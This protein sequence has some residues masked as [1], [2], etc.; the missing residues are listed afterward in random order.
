MKR[1]SKLFIA[2]PL[3]FGA[4]TLTGCS[5]FDNLANY[6]NEKNESKVYAKGIKL[7]VKNLDGS[8]NNS[9][10]IECV[11]NPTNTTNQN[12]TW[13]SS[14]TGVCTV[15]DGLVNC[16][17]LGEA[18]ITAVSEDGGFTDTCNVT[19]RSKLMTG[20]SLSKKTATLKPGKS[21]T[22]SVVFEPNDCS[23]KAITWTSSNPSI[24]SVDQ[25][26]VITAANDA[27]DGQTATITARAKNFIYSDSCEVTILESAGDLEKTE[28]AWTYKD[29]SK[30]S[31]YNSKFCPTT[32]NVKL[33]V[34]PVWFTDSQLKT[35]LNET[36]RETVREDIRKT[37]FGTQGETGWHS[38]KT[39]YETE[40]TED[41]ENLLTLSGTVSEWF[42]C[43]KD[44]SRFATD[45]AK[46][47]NTDSFAVE[48]TDWYFANHPSDN[49]KNYDSDGDG[50]LDGVMLIY[51]HPDYMTISDHSY[52][53][54]WAYCHW[55]KG[56]PNISSPRPDV[57]FWASYDFMYGSHYKVGNYAGGDNTGAVVD[58]HT[59][60][61][62]MGH[63]FGLED[64]YDYSKQKNPA[65]CFSMQDYNIGGH[66]P[67]SMISLG[68]V[69][70]YIPTDTCEIKLKPFQTNHDVILLTPEM[71]PYGSPFDEY[72]LIEYYTPT[73]LNAL[74][75]SRKYKNSIS[76]PND[77]GIRVWHVDARV[78]GW[79]GPSRDDVLPS[80]LGSNIELS[81]KV[82]QAFKNT[83][84]SSDEYNN[85]YGS[86]LGAAYSE[87]NMLQV[88]RNSETASVYRNSSNASLNEQFSSAD[89]FK[90]GD[91]FSIQKFHRQFVNGTSNQLNK[92]IPLG[93]TFNVKSLTTSEAT[94]EITSL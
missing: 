1:F 84:Y 93:F 82:L 32:G 80:T 76:G 19:V 94:I 40:S 92:G 67:Y 78:V 26:G 51:A 58:S 18:T 48:A 50:I 28:M 15:N 54:Y 61:H 8:L 38:V 87:Y 25:N 59:F 63:V 22:L 71:N 16:V 89:M 31:A 17:G 62:E 46:N 39:Y 73:G 24:V 12:V 13:T 83:Y 21:R 74:D 20:L 86:P 7:S 79:Q 2:L 53:N 5:F 49:R 29:Y 64:Y 66:D 65:G 3:F 47:T 30:H 35:G 37:Y 9:Y 88:I 27:V 70:P 57:Y 34:I 10:K 60:I 36:K 81:V 75:T 85:S 55:C 91:T 11:F 14:N 69:K 45:D 72:I 90:Q 56:T 41:G 4:V 43:G 23:D 6:F 52:N 42:E 77:Y 68:W 33:L 44:S